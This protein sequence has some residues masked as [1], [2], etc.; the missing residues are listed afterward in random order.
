MIFSPRV[1]ANLSI[2]IGAVISNKVRSLLTALG[3]IFGV[4]A[5]IAMLAIGNGAQREI[6]DQ[7]KLVGV[8]NIV[9]KPITEQ[10]EEKIE[11]QVGQKDKKKFSPGLTIRDV[12]NI[13]STI[14][15]IASISPEI[16]LDTYVIRNGL[17]RSAKLVGVEPVYFK[18]YNFDLLDGKSFS[19][20]QERLGSPVCVIGS[21]IK[22]KFFPTENPIGKTIK[23]GQHWLTIIGI[24]KERL[25]SESSISKLGI[26]DFNMDI[27]T[28]I[29]S[30][31]IRYK[32]RDKIT[33]EQ[34]RLE[35]MRSRGMVFSSTQNAS[36]QS[37][38]EKKNYH[39]LDRLVVQVNETSQL[40]PTAEILSR[41]LQRRH[42]DV[43]DY[44]I[45]IPEMLL[46]QQQRTNDIFNYVLGAIAGISL[47]VGGIGIM[48]IMLASVLERIKEIGLRLSIGAKK[49][50]VVQQFLFE[51]IMI[52]VS[53]GIIGV[54]LGVTLAYLVSKFAGIPTIITFTSI[55]LSFGVAA[56]VGLIFGIAPARRAASQD[57]ITS[58][59]YE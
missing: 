17:R 50:D 11:E 52:S 31:L 15:G 44:E 2:A 21:S 27:Y 1:L 58:L 45:E 40:A 7:I 51:A 25:V 13:K 46:K 16:I 42:Y 26:R 47:L 18:I 4:A 14:P 29:Q 35:S 39:Q 43:V 23:V 34:L 55:I 59:R 22:A 8:N 24:L 56:T 57:P 32:N 28:P 9:I 6:L 20:E 3:I 53:G 12:S 5:V 41:L 49:S 33:S 48:N 36:D 10:K 30:V 19:G 54:A 38:Q 37:E